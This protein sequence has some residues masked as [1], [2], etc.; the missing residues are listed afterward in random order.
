MGHSRVW[1]PSP[2]D[3]CSKI[4]A[5]KPFS[6][7]SHF[8]FPQPP[9]PS[10]GDSIVVGLIQQYQKM[11]WSVVPL[12]LQIFTLIIPHLLGQLYL[13]RVQIEF[14]Q[15]QEFW[16]E[17]KFSFYL[18]HYHLSSCKNIVELM[19]KKL[20]KG[21]NGYSSPNQIQKCLQ[22]GVERG[23]MKFLGQLFLWF[24]AAEGN[25]H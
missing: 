19:L 8:F 15:P 5:L 18:S 24:Y 14:Q 20:K 1:M 2:L 7:F 13:Q 25:C 12:S 4:S 22:V 23:E 21:E 10:Q 11:F 3:F 16:V 17:Q 9:G 6:S